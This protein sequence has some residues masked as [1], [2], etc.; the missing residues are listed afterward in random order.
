MPDTV[1]PRLIGVAIPTLRELRA[2]VL[3]SGGA[4]DG[5]ANA[6]RLLREAGYAGGDAI[7]EAFEHWLAES[8]PDSAGE[9]RETVAPGVRASSLS[10]DEF[11]ARA[12][13][14]FGDAGWGEMT[15]TGREDAG[16]AEVGISDCWESAEEIESPMPGCH[17]TT[18]TLASFF[19]RVAGYPMAV[20]ETECRANGAARCRFT[21]GNAE[22]MNYKWDQLR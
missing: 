21:M 15:F 17:V 12:S 4:G 5:N 1:T 7:F 10:I 14:F 16:V 8:I 11:G 9:V 19:G 20:L 3:S 22:V 6:V 18:G 2:G 13:K